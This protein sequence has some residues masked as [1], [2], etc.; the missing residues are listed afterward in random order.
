MVKGSKKGEDNM[1][2]KLKFEKPK[3]DAIIMNKRG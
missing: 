2:I 3:S 1:E